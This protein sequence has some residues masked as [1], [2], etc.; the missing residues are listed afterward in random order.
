MPGSSSS[1]IESNYS[2]FFLKEGFLAV[3]PPEPGLETGFFSSFFYMS[4]IGCFFFCGG[5]GVS[6]TA[7]SSSDESP[8][9]LKLLGFALFLKLLLL[10]TFSL[11]N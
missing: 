9:K 11:A 3:L 8:P 1:W 2:G 7:S 6:S 4:R 10:I 5:E